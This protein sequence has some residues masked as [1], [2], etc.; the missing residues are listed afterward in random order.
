M[1]STSHEL[2]DLRGSSLDHRQSL[3]PKSE[4]LNSE[5]HRVAANPTV[6]HETTPYKPPSGW[7]AIPWKLEIL[8]WIGSLCFFI[9]IIVV[10]R[11][12]NG[13]PLPDLQFG[14]QPSAILGLLATFG[15]ALLIA[16]VS[17]ALG[18]IKWLQALEERPM[19]NFETLDK[20]SRGSFGSTLLIAGRKSGYVI[21][22]KLLSLA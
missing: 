1:Q 16:P 8:C 5:S 6:G 15:Q 13:R 10:L 2:Q 21:S 4:D 17:S 3:L 18:Q 20:A 12:L 9:A 22:L 11:V 14:I 19:N 7:S